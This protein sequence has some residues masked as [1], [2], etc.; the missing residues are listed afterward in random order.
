MLENKLHH[1]RISTGLNQKT[2]QRDGI[3]VC[4]ALGLVFDGR[5]NIFNDLIERLFFEQKVFDFKFQIDG[6]KRA[7]STGVLDSSYFQIFISKS[8]D[9]T[10][11]VWTS[12]GPQKK[13]PANPAYFWFTRST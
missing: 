1:G 11:R 5:N 13:G 6:Q 12:N 8:A 3:I 9:L 2:T 10:W 7:P 4:H